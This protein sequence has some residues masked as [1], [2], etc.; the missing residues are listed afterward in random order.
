MKKTGLGF[1]LFVLVCSFTIKYGG[2][3]PGWFKAG[4]SPES[5]EIG[6]EN[7]TDRGGKVAFLKSKEKSIKGFGTLMQNFVPKE[8]LGKKVKLTAFIKAN[9]VSDWAG[10]WMRI[11]G[12]QNGKN[13]NKTLGFD[14]MQD[15]PLKGTIGW[16]K[17]EIILKVPENAINLAYGVLIS[18][19]GSV[20]MDDIQFEIVSDEIKTTGSEGTLEK[21]T[22][23][24][25]ED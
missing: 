18:K 3:I 14:N 24:K 5:Y 8:Y 13:S 20:W 1:I 7:D 25:F 2:E 15:R 12:E 19:T 9:E 11:D 10:M 21:P 23:T 22:N 6:I 16:K 4:S 17:Y